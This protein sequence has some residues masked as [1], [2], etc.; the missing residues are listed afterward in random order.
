DELSGPVPPNVPPAPPGA[1]E[2]IGTRHD[3]THDSLYF[4][5]NVDVSDTVRATLGGEFEKVE[6]HSSER[7]RAAP[8]LGISWDATSRAEV[9]AAVI[10]NLQPPHVSKH[11][12]LSTLEPTQ[13]AGFN[14]Q[15]VGAEGEEAWRYGVAVDYEIAENL[16]AGVEFSRRDVEMPFLTIDATTS[17]TTQRTAV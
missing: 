14:Q 10:G 8:K 17:V 4:Y 13:V 3:V 6:S 2:V 9:R 16:F 5:A 12:A 7:G 11:N 15:Y 1:S